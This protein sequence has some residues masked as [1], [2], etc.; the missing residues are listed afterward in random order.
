ML[1]IL[2]GLVPALGNLVAG[3][4][5]KEVATIGA[6]IAKEVLGTDDP[7]GMEAA[8]ADPKN[9][10]AFKARLELIA[11][12]VQA[13]SQLAIAETEKGGFWNSWRPAL[14]WIVIATIA[15]KLIISPSLQ[16]AIGVPIPVDSDLLEKVVGWWMAVYM[17][18]HTVKF[19]VGQLADALK[20]KFAK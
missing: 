19:G 18:G 11:A 7:A 2:L 3:G 14:A 16:A 17:G 1:E 6:Q 12:Q 10:E 15:T 20:T 9:V 13:A 4:K 5:G 8:L